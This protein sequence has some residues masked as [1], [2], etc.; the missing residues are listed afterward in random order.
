MIDFDNRSAPAAFRSIARA[1]LL[2]GICMAAI[3]STAAAARIITA[4]ATAEAAADSAAESAENEIIVTGS[5]PI[6]ESEAAALIIQRNSDSLVSVLAADSIGRLPDQNIAQAISRLPGVSVQRDQGQARYVNLRGAP[7]N[8]TTLSFDGI[9]VVSPEG[10]D[11]RFDSIPSA[12]ASQVIVQK[13]VTPDLNGETIAGNVNIVTRS[14]FDYKGFHIAT[15]LGAGYVELG[16]GTE[17]EGSLV[18]SNR[19]NTGI[20]EI[21]VLLSGSYYR[22]N[23]VTDN[24]EIDWE[25]VSRDLRPAV[26]GE[27]TPRVWAREIENKYYRLT[28]K[29]YSAT[30][31]LEW[32]PDSDNKV[33][34]S[35]IYTIFADDELRDNYRVDADDQQSRVPNSTAPCPAGADAPAPF[36]TGYADVCTGNTPLTGT[37]YGVDFD[38]RFR[39]TKYRQSVFTNTVGGDHVLGDWT[40]KWRGNYTRSQ[41]DRSLPYLHTYQSPGFGS[42]GVG[43]VDRPTV[44]YDLTDKNNSHIS[45]FR[46]LRSPTGVLSR[47]AGLSDYQSFPNGIT[48]ATALDALDVTDAYTAKVEAQWNTSLFGDTVLRFGGQFDQRTKEANERLLTAQ[49]S[50]LNTA[51]T[52]QGIPLNLSGILGTDPFKGKIAPGYMM[53]HFSDAKAQAIVRVAGSLGTFVPQNQNFYNVREKIW[54]GFA[55]G[56]TRFDWGNIVYGARVENITNTGTAFAIIGSAQQL[57]TIE[58]SKTLVFPSA[59]I[60]WNAREDMKVRLSFNTGA[61]RPDYTVSRP[62]LT[63]NDADESISGGNPLA[64][65]ERAKGVDLYWEWYVLPRGFVSLGVF[66]KD[67]TDV[68]FQDTTVFGLDI[69]NT[70][71]FPNR[72]QYDFTTTVNG[73]DG[74]IAGVE[75]AVQFQLDSFLD[76]DSWIGGFGIQANATYTQSEATTPDG[77]KIQFPGTSEWT[78]NV[79]PYYEKYGFSAR[80]SYQKRTDWLSEIGTPADT[81]GDI[82]WAADD[83]LDISARYAITSNF[84]VYVDASNLLNGPGRRYAG[85]SQRTIEHET[86]GP[87]VQA[88]IRLTY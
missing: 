25:T 41:D 81:G 6:A 36:T 45:L 49:G 22:R 79:G 8:W 43:A 61:A 32:R 30:G 27:E 11:A 71:A 1:S 70:A 12:I 53:T 5:R 68:L 16:G 50:S 69:L 42:N 65:P 87:R 78:Y 76:S 54:S 18:V 2:A 31:R 88:G 57:V 7:L 82:F 85:I 56:T 40:V 33:F 29:N 28:R 51:L 37:I 23:M 9:F 10:R 58:N 20:G 44:Q 80:L 48:S 19:W 35:S 84:E 47:G 52:A 73:G 63:V 66:Y 67:V 86:F 59:H 24:F 74:Y 26:A 55:M 17:V 77:R 4:A 13:A 83:E 3:A 62:N 34:I 15:K 60:N 72:V 39:A 38:A 46:T 75:G 21:G 64:L 14:P